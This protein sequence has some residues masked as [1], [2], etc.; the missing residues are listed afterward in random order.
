ME[1]ILALFKYLAAGLSPTEFLVVIGIIVGATFFLVR[2]FL[3]T[4][5]SFQGCWVA[6]KK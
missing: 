5:I 4:V 6:R 1:T 3:K 2:L